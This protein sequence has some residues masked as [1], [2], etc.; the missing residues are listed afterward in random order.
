MPEL[1]PAYYASVALRGPWWTDEEPSLRVPRVSGGTPASIWTT[2]EGP[3]VLLVPP[4]AGS[5]SHDLW[6]PLLPVLGKQF[7]VHAM[8][9]SG[10]SL[11][12]D[13]EHVTVAADAIGAD[14]LAGFAD[15]IVLLRDAGRQAQRVRRAV[16]LA[17]RGEAV[18]TD[19]LD[20]GFMCCVE[21]FSGAIAELTAADA[22][23]LA[24]NLNEGDEPP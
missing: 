11:A 4:N 5:A 15:D 17:F 18:A 3:N 7:T 14:Y 1:P 9:R 21:L 10:V 22:Q 16:V 6:S 12:D 8:D 24:D 2:G 13:L 19:L 20:P 23:R